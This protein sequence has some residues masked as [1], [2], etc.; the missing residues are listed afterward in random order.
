MSRHRGEDG[1]ALL[2]ALVVMA[3]AA[4]FAAT[5][6][7][8]VLARQG[9]AAA[10]RGA[11]QAEAL[12]R[13]ALSAACQEAR[14]GRWS[15]GGGAVSGTFGQQA[16][17]RGAW[18]PLPDPSPT[19]WLTF[20]T[21]AEGT[22]GR[23]RRSVDTLVQLRR[24][25]FACG[26]VVSGDAEFAAPL[27]VSGCG[28]YSGGSV[29][30]REWVSFPEADGAP[31]ADRVRGDLWPQAGVHALG[32]IWTRGVEEH[33]DDPAAVPEDTDTHSAVNE[34]MGAVSAPPE[35]WLE[36]VREWADDPG[37]ALQDGVLMLDRIP[38]ARSAADGR[39][40]DSGFIVWLPPGDS[41]VRIVGI[42]P[43]G[44]CPVLVV[45]GADVSIGGPT[46]D[47]SFSGAVVTAGHLEVEGKTSID[48]GLYAGS[49]RVA[50]ALAFTVPP[51]WRTQPIPGLIVP[52]IVAI[53]PSAS[54]GN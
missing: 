6:V 30:G 44:W 53:E 52:V 47:T 43:T 9:V 51:S 17:W 49:L 39:A 33:D 3:L 16:D 41:P 31:A 40:S 14:R 34:V 37:S 29:R 10:D 24:A 32:G 42:R 25:S 15:S 5:S 54:A 20:S 35:D 45:S 12:Q 1:Y 22:F 19:A 7:A 4:I 26:L 23:A 27:T 13:R 2:A 46:A 11:A 18:S 36:T 8:A 48:G 50:S 38:A 21:I 28:V